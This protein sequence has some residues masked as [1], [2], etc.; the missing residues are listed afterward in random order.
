MSHNHSCPGH[1]GLSCIGGWLYSSVN[2]MIFPTNK[3][4]PTCSVEVDPEDPYLATMTGRRCP[5]DD[6]LCKH[7][8]EG[9][10]CWRELDGS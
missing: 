2:M 10:S 9:D 5:H 7:D 3:K 6:Q 1:E 8:C 4:C